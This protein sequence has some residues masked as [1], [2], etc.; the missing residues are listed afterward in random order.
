MSKADEIVRAIAD[1]LI[2]LADGDYRKAQV[3]AAAYLPNSDLPLCMQP[4]F[5]P[6][7]PGREAE[8]RSFGNPAPRFGATDYAEDWS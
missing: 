8:A 3:L 4:G 6:E 7:Q 2:A 5:D 1:G